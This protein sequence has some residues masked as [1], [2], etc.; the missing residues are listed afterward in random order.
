M[1][2]IQYLHDYRIRKATRMLLEGKKSISEISESCGFC[3][4]SYFGRRFQEVFG[5]SPREYRQKP[6]VNEKRACPPRLFG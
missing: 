1:S 6:P 2:T 5:C 3:T 4:P